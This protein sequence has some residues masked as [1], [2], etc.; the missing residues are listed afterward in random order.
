MMRL[1]VAFAVAMSMG[2][3][4]AF[5]QST[6][7]PAHPP[8]VAARIQFG[9]RAPAGVSRPTR[10]TDVEFAR[11]GRGATAATQRPNGTHESRA[12][13]GGRRE[14]VSRRAGGQ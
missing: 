14:A 3:A 12:C 4:A 13:T 1:S 6:P 2:P 10:G 9:A 11:F 5:A 8:A 7:P